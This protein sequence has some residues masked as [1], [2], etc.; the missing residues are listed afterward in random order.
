M[1]SDEDMMT[2]I[3]MMSYTYTAGEMRYLR[4]SIIEK[5]ITVC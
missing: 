5:R 4:M 3:H 2:R 1:C